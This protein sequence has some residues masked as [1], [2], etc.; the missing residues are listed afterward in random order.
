MAK[1]FRNLQNTLYLMKGISESRFTNK[2]PLFRHSSI[3]DGLVSFADK[4]AK[5][6]NSKQLFLKY[7]VCKS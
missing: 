2:P 4:E 1:L 6:Q 5:L 3:A 7:M